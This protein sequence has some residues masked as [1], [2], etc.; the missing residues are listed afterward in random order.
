LVGLGNGLLFFQDLGPPFKW[1]FWAAKI[2]DLLIM[3]FVVGGNNLAN[4][5]SI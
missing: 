2:R 3:G 5:S 4:N 1:N